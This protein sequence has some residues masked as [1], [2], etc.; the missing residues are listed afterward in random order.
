V[1]A[2]CPA[3]TLDGAAV[4]LAFHPAGTRL[5]V[6]SVSQSIRIWDMTVPLG[7]VR[8]LPLAELVGHD[9]AVTSVAYSP[10]GRHLAS[11]STDHTVRLWDAE[12][13][14]LLG[15]ATLDTQVKALS[16]SP[17]GRYLYTGN[18]NSSCYQ[19]EVRS[20]LAKG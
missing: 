14:K 13:G 10:D 16:F 4:A 7:G 12:T 8:H 5:A 20:L 18:G 2:R 19:I 15:S 3:G 17:D 11:G 1:E 9:E 6:A